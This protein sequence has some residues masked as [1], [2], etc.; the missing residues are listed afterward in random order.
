MNF[1]LLYGPTAAGKLSVANEL[2]GLTGYKLLDNH[3]V[4]NTIA[5]LFPFEDPKLNKIRTRLGRRFRLE[6]F[7]E[8]AIA[9][10]DFI[11][12]C[13]ISSPD[14]FAF[15]KEAKAAVE[16]HGSDVHIVQLRPTREA[17]MERVASESRKGVKVCSAEHLERELVQKPMQFD[18]LPGIEHMIIDNTNLQ[19]RVVAAQIVLHYQLAANKNSVKAPSA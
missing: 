2:V 13:I 3:K 9:G 4:L 5:A 19:P 8:A 14:S 12:T 11:S 6:L 18:T 10:V 15:I 7:E 1:V 17:L 16:R